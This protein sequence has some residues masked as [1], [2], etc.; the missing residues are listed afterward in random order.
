MLSLLAIDCRTPAPE[1]WFF[2]LCLGFMGPSEDLMEALAPAAGKMHKPMSFCLQVQGFPGV[3][4]W[5]QTITSLSPPALYLP[6]VS[7]SPFSP[8]LTKFCGFY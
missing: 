2:T 4:F 3:L 1:R 7:P 8:N 6:T 5:T